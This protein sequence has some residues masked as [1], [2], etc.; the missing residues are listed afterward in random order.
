MCAF[1]CLRECLPL[2]PSYFLA[3]G[4]ADASPERATLTSLGGQVPM[5]LHL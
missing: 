3:G 1:Y 5:E 2:S 4:G